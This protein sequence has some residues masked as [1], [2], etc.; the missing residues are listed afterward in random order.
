[1]RYFRLCWLPPLDVVEGGGD[2]S[3]FDSELKELTSDPVR[4]RTRSSVRLPLSA[5]DV[6]PDDY[7]P[8]RFVGLWEEEN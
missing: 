2:P 6:F 3:F 1:M 4:V 7:G 8:K 5:A